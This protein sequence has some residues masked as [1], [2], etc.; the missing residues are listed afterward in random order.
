MFGRVSLRGTYAM[1]DGT[2]NQVTDDIPVIFD[3]ESS[4]KGIE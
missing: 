1:D 2:W 4:R 3:A